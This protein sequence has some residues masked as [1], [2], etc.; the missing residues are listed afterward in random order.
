LPDSV[1]ERRA[2]LPDGLGL[3]IGPSA[4][5]EEDGSHSGFQIDPK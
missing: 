5:G 4:I 1:V 2:N 3:A